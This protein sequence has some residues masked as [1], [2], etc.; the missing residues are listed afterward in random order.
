MRRLLRVLATPSTH[1]TDLKG[2]Q[3]PHRGSMSRPLRLQFVGALYHITSRGDGQEPIYLDD[4]DRKVFLAVLAQICERYHWVCHSYCLMTNHYHLTY[5]DTRG[6]SL[7][8]NP[9]RHGC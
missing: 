6:H 9:R 7:P 4:S 2:C 1:I 8:R 5:R 3:Q